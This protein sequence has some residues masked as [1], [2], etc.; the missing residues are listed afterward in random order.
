MADTGRLKVVVVVVVV[1]AIVHLSG[2]WE[3]Y[4]AV[5]ISSPWQL[6]PGMFPEQ[7]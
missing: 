7:I 5:P 2:P 3:G 1:V 4:L 6:W